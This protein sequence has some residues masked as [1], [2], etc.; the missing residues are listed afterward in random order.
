MDVKFE[1]MLPSVT[2]NHN[3]QNS[4]LRIIY[5]VQYY[6]RNFHLYKEI[7]YPELNTQIQDLNISFHLSLE[8]HENS[9]L[10]TVTA[11]IEKDLNYE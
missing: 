1:A 6:V 5:G 8:N 4:T 3:S 10:N 11:I 7:K 2:S 9:A